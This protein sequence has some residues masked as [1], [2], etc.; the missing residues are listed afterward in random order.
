MSCIDVAIREAS[1]KV[2]VEVRED[3]RVSLVVRELS[4]G[5]MV[6]V[7]DEQM[8]RVAV[9]DV[10]EVRA[11]VSVVCE[12]ADIKSCIDGGGW[13]DDLPWLD[14]SNWKD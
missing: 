1:D 5:V 12:L 2:R 8:P 9:C 6:R 10:G 13:R 4:Q 3:V 7:Q 11:W 14:G